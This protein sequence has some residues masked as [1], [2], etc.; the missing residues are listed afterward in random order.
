MSP[1]IRDFHRFDRS[2]CIIGAILIPP[3]MG[4]IM[5]VGYGIGIRDVAL[6]RQAGKNLALATLIALVTSASR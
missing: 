5:G 4:P 3:L 6:V 2:Q 1:R